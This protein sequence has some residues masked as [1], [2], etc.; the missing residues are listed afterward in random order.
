MRVIF[1]GFDVFSHVGV[2]IM[3]GLGGTLF[4][5]LVGGGGIIHSHA[6]S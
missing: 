3:H 4:G 5:W 6:S 1:G 2:C